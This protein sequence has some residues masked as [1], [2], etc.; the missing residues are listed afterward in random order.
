MVGNMFEKQSTSDTPKKKERPPKQRRGAFR[1][2]SAAERVGACG[3][4]A[5]LRLLLLT[6]ACSRL[7]AGHVPNPTATFSGP[8]EMYLSGE[9]AMPVFP[10]AL[11]TSVR[12]MGYSFG[13]GTERPNGFPFP[14]PFIFS[15][16]RP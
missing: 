1:S 13:A 15:Q 11:D 9:L 3:W 12:G 7:S 4:M 6:Q 8:S 2:T 16:G 10:P 14:F 5:Q